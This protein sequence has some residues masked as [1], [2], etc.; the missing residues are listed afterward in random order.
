MFKQYGAFAVVTYLSVYVTTLGMLYVGVKLG[1]IA[2][3]DVNTWINNWRVKKFFMDTPVDIPD[4]IMDFA[5]AWV[6][7]KTTEPIRLV[8]TIAILPFLVKR[9]PPGARRL[10][11][12]KDQPPSAH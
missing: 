1:L 12:M 7:T 9:L 11:R 5:V 6:L 4:S 10:F 3:P 8:V 2:K